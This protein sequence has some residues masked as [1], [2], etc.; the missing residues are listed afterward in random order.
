[1]VVRCSRIWGFYRYDTYTYI[2]HYSY[3]KSNYVIK[4]LKSILHLNKE[5]AS[6]CLRFVLNTAQ[7]ESSPLTKWVSDRHPAHSWKNSFLHQ[8][9]IESD[10]TIARE[11]VSCFKLLGLLFGHIYPGIDLLTIFFLLVN[12]CESSKSGISLSPKNSRSQ[13]KMNKFKNER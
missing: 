9:P 5:D 11:T 10:Q 8:E 12:D 6:V 3:I 4:C 7:N 13:T 1:M 2:N